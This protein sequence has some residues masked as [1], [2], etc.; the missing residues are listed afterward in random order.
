VA[1]Y[2]NPY[3]LL[4]SGPTPSTTSTYRYFGGLDVFI[5]NAGAVQVATLGASGAGKYLNSNYDDTKPY[6]SQPA[7]QSGF[8]G[9]VVPKS[10]TT[11]PWTTVPS[12]PTVT[13]KTE[14]LEQIVTAGQSITFTPVSATGGTAVY[15]NYDTITGTIT[16]AANTSTSPLTISISPALPVGMNWYPSKTNIVAGTVKPTQ[17]AYYSS[18]A[19]AVNPPQYR[20]TYTIASNIGL[21][22]VVGQFY[23]VRGQTKV[24]Y[25]GTYKCTN[26][27]ADT[28]TL[29][30]LGS[31]GDPSYTGGAA[32]SL[33]GYTGQTGWQTSSY[34]TITDADVYASVRTDGSTQYKDWQNYAAVTIVGTPQNADVGTKTYTVTFTDGSSPPKSGSASFKI[35]TNPGAADLSYTLDISSRS[36]TQGT[37]DSFKPLSAAGGTTPYTYSI[38]SPPSLPAGLSI[39][40]TTGVISGTPTAYSG[41]TQYTVKVA[42]SAGA[43]KT[44]VVILTVTAPAVVATAVIPSTYQFNRTIPFTTFKPVNGSGGYGGLRYS[45]ASLP[46][47]LSINTTTGYISGT[48]TVVTAAT[49]YVITVTDYNTPVASTNNATITITVVDLPA[50]NSTVSPAAPYTLTKK[51]GTYSFT[52]VTG[53]GGYLPQGTSLLYTITGTVSLASIG[54]SI[55]S[56]NGVIS[57]N[58]TALLVPTNFTITV[59]DQAV[60]PQTSSGTFSIEVV[61]LA[62]STFLDVP[63]PPPAIKNVAIA[64]FRPVSA[65]GGDGS[66]TYSILP[67]ITSDTGLSFN[68]ST[69]Y[70]YGTATSVIGNTP[71]TVTVTDQTTPSPQTSSKIFTLRVDAPPVLIVSAITEK[72]LTQYDTFTAFTPVVANGGYGSLN[73]SISPLLPTGLTFATNGVN[74]GQISGPATK[75]LITATAFTVTIADQAAQSTSSSFLLT[76]KTRPLVVKTDK[77]KET[78]I[79]SVNA[80]S[81]RPVSATGGSETYGYELDIGLPAG[82]LFSTSTGFISGKATTTSTTTTY[83]VSITDTLGVSGISTFDLNVVEPPPIST[84]L[85]N[86]T[87]SSSTFYKSVTNVN[88][89]PVGAGGGY[90]SITF[91]INPDV[92][93][94]TGLT[95]GTNGVL[96]GYATKYVDKIY[97][98]SATDSIGQSSSTNY[99]IKITYVPLSITQVVVTSVLT[100]SKTITPFIPATSSGGSGGTSFTISPDITAN[101]GLSFDGSI[102]RIYGT[103]SSTCT[104]TAY[105]ITAKDTDNNTAS[106]T[107]NIIVNEPAPI[108]TTSTTASVTLTVNQSFTAFTPVTASGGDGQISYVIGPTLPLGLTFDVN[109]GAI[110]GVPGTTSTTATYVVTATDALFQ[111]SSSSF[112]LDILPQPISITT[113]YP[114]LVYTKYTSVTPVIPVLAT[115]GFGQKAYTIIGNNLPAGLIYNTSIGEISGTPSETSATTLYSVVVTDILG[116]TNSGTFTLT[117]NDVLPDPLTAVASDSLFSLSIGNSVT[118]HAVTGSGGVG[119]Y[120]YAISPLT[121]PAGLSFN[122]STGDISGTP[123]STATAALYSITIT[124]N[125]PQSKSAS[126]SI[127]VI[128]SLTGGGKGYTGSRG[129]TGSAGYA[130]SRGYSGSLG[131]TGSIGYTGS[132]GIQGIQGIQGTDGSQGIQGIQGTDGIQGI[133]GTDGIQGIQGTDGLQGIQGT[134]G[135]LGYTGSASTAT[136]Y[137]GS[138]GVPGTPGT[139]VVIVG[140]T[141]SYSTL[142]IPYLGNIGDGYILIDTGHLAV[143]SGTIWNDV[144]EFIGYTGSQGAQGIQG[145]DGS[146]GIQGIQGTDGIQGIQGTD[147]SQ[148]I[149]GPQ[150]IQGTQGTDGLQ[151]IQG[152]QGTDGLQGIQGTQGTDGL[153][154]IQG[155]DGLQGIQGIQGTDGLQGIQGTQGTDG[156]QGI[157]GIRGFIGV[158][159]IQG[160]VG[161]TGSQGIR[162]IQGTDGSQGIQ[163]IQGTDGIQG[164][165]GTDGSQGIQGIQGTDGLQGIQGIQGIIGYTGSQ[166][167]QGVIGYTGSQGIQGVQGI[168]GIIGYT[169]SQG[170]QGIVGYTGSQGIQGIQGIIGY[171]G[172]QGIQG[173]VG[174]TGSQGIQ[175]VIGYT[176]SHGDTGVFIGATPPPTTDI[177]WLD[178]VENPLVPLVPLG[179]TEGQVLVKLSSTDFDVAWANGIQGIQGIQGRQGVQGIQGTQG[180]VGY[181]GSIGYTGS[182]GEAG[183]FGG[184]AFEYVY[185]SDTTGTDP[186]SG[187]IEFNTSTFSTS[188]TVAYINFYDR[189]SE[190]VYSYLQTIDDSTSLIKGHFSVTEK[191]DPNNYGLFA[192]TGSHTEEGTPSINHFHIPIA[193]LS[194]TPTFTN[195]MVVIVTFA[196]TGD[197]GDNGI[198]GYTG[199]QGQTGSF[200]STTAQVVNITNISISTSTTTGALIVAGGVGIGGNLNVGGNLNITGNITPNIY[201]PY[202]VGLF[203]N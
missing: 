81:Y 153:Q 186:A 12:I 161:Y 62:L 80:T 97:T 184:A 147:G 65:S 181:T 170:I 41:A 27:I 66:Y 10:E 126:F 173:I 69:G 83:S 110:S 46:T 198:Q 16:G 118:L 86:P 50:L 90:G 127:E 34:V 108:L 2:F 150:G 203:Y 120:T 200:T 28:I 96:S 100:R 33:G 6:L 182:K 187:Q 185:S 124:D 39:N 131:Y 77:Q 196:R 56:T 119:T 42:D 45:A 22:P 125:T 89:A 154:G 165:Q 148:G 87:V 188:T 122:T 138:Q 74:A 105:T 160:I 143:W 17:D 15:T 30:Y 146:Q 9:S 115:G 1:I 113:P 130:G 114:T 19:G 194:G 57:G 91:S 68:T 164:I 162:G 25:N 107:T 23:T 43:S 26:Y 36:L 55:N 31:S 169:G 189:L 133:Q 52:P 163:G 157:Q 59:S 180:V 178:T 158:Q 106:T 192:I 104:D 47:G 191:A 84:F 24:S 136:G 137:T 18:V 183:S 44:D 79:R 176:G 156:L 117:V 155:T 139:S 129:Y 67:N 82:L 85:T 4:P 99:A 168:Q 13:A 201:N 175:G 8:W 111:V 134:Q 94:D 63:T 3:P 193:Y 195:G 141:S 116:Q 40:P 95:F 128:Q 101:I 167:I 166:G 70:V 35:T 152:T 58:P 177:L 197:R 20:V 98:I 32:T 145:T 171:T 142:I 61:A 11:H 172:S 88:L 202:L 21:A 48:G 132:Q 5:T 38:V 76:V 159:G 109:T 199:S 14:I 7:G 54:L 71:Y 93:T 72:I 37:A 64:N 135:V 92:K 112:L 51:S 75:Y 103:P 78:F 73:Y 190:S 29:E 53:S 121:L 140:S 60:P 151:G 149:Q 49:P 123:T 144:G 179:G 174:Y 102:G